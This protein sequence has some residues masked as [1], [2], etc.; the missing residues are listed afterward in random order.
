MVWIIASGTH[1]VGLRACPNVHI[2]S[3]VGP[4]LRVRAQHLQ[5]RGPGGGGRRGRR[6]GAAVM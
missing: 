3:H 5:Q 2:M 4:E 1:C 6:G